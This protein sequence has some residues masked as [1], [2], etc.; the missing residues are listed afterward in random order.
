M[1]ISKFNLVSEIIERTASV[2]QSEPEVR[3]LH[4]ITV[5]HTHTLKCISSN[6]QVPMDHKT[7]HIGSNLTT[8]KKSRKTSE[9]LKHTQFLRI[10]EK[11]KAEKGRKILQP[12]HSL[13]NN[14][15]TNKYIMNF[16]LFNFFSK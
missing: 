11:I 1:K 7:F 2:C 4:T 6:F 15:L 5:K 14:N 13:Y 16:P 9:V 10:T 12:L 8:S 3:K